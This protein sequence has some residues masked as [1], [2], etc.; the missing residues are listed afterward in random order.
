ME[1]RNDKTD[2]IGRRYLHIVHIH[3][4]RSAAGIQIHLEA[5]S[6][7]EG[8]SGRCGLVADVR[9]HSLAVYG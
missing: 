5:C 3:V 8:G 4:I 7:L 2:L 6:E 9:A 1:R